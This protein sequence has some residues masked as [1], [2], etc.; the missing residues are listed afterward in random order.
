M[1]PSDK[2]K[3]FLLHT[4]DRLKETGIDQGEI[5][6]WETELGTARTFLNRISHHGVTRDAEIYISSI[7]RKQKGQVRTDDLSENGIQR[8]V[9]QATDQ[10][11]H[12]APLRSFPLLPGPFHDFSLKK[13]IFYDSTVQ[14]SP[15]ERMNMVEKMIR[16]S[17]KNHLKCSAKLMTGGGKLGVINSSGTLMVTEFSEAS[18]SL[19]LTGEKMISAYSSGSSENF[20]TL[21]SDRIIREAIRN[22]DRQTLPQADHLVSKGNDLCFDLILEPYAAAEWVETAAAIGFNG[23]RYEEGE[24]FIS[25]KLNQQIFGE[26]I[27]IHD[28]AADPRGFI[29][30]FDFEGFPKTRQALVEKGIAKSICYDTFLGDQYGKKDTGHALPPFERSWGAV[31]RHLIMEGGA[32]S[33]EEM[34]ASSEEPTLYVTRF[35][36]TNVVNPK[37]GILTGMTKDGTFLIQDGKMTGPVSNLR[38]LE[39]I[40][41]A[42]KRVVNLGEPR[43]VHDP[44][45]YGGLYP[46]SSI[47][48]PLKI[49][50]VKFIGTSE[51]LAGKP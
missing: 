11:R 29:A 42:L 10:A 1:I 22:A 8:A 26:N 37:E 44:V 2:I 46:E 43:L 25:G 28:D 9:R 51:N 3:E 30:P 6:Y 4:M 16:T 18:L 40:S 35:H 27:T 12:A 48:P 34:I 15:G 21:D 13:K 24:S 47:V 50:K 5:L 38:F 23:L 14:L 45:G 31:P 49:R 19:I 32:S 7:R 36:Y 41:E 20:E 17:N 39:S 33:L